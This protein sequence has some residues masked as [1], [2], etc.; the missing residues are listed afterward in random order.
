MAKHRFSEKLRYKFDNI[1]ARGTS[2]MIILLGT[3]SLFFLLVLSAIVWLTNTAPEEAGGSYLQIFWMSLMRTL[4]S[5]T[6]GGDS[7]YFGLLMLGVTCVGIFVLSGL[8][9][10][11]N[12]GIEAKLENIRKGKSKVI[13]KDHTVIFGWSDQIFTV[14]S[15]LI[16]SN[17]SRKKACIV[18]MGNKEKPEIE[19][20]IRAEIPDTRSTRIVCR[21]GDP[22]D[23][24]DIEIANLDEARSII[25]LSPDDS[26]T[27]DAEVIKSLLAITNN[28]SRKQGKYNIVAEIRDPKNLEI[29]KLVG[30]DEAEIILI[31]DLI[32]RI[33]A[34]T[35][36]QSGLSV[37]YNELLDFDGAEIY[38]KNEAASHG[39][40]Y[41]EVL[42][43][44]NNC[45]IMGII[46]ENSPAMLNPP[47][48][49]VIKSTDELVIIAGDDSDIRPSGEN[50][51]QIHTD[52]ITDRK[53]VILSPERTLLLGWNWRAPVIIR[54]LDNYVPDG[55]TVF[56]AADS[57]G[58]QQQIDACCKESLRKLT[59]QFRDVDTT[60]RAVLDSLKV[61][62]YDHIILLCYSDDLSPQQAD[63]RT[64]VTLLHLRDISEKTGKNFNIV[65]EMLNIKNRDLAQVTKVNDFIVSDKIVSLMLS[66]ISENKKINLV[67]SDMFDPDG[68]EIYLKPAADY[69]REGVEVNFATVVGSAAKKNE[70]AIGY[71]I[72]ALANDESK[73]FGV[74]VNPLKSQNVRFAKKDMVI[75]LTDS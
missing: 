51:I 23:L 48:D 74:C 44:Y 66:Q 34:Q 54:E 1:M 69:V 40:K 14:I 64:L 47:M 13:E 46:P 67:F 7:G 5:G 31:G 36:R 73:A 68:A 52:A 2:S 19:D 38:I 11:I 63:S 59:V 42:S 57:A 4:D 18:V 58:A 10:I 45:S 37:V 50:A 39:K 24:N 27:P 17:S 30:K 49:R 62:Q 21:Q 28:P 8:I 41:S 53:E 15:E 3:L 71:K 29:A 70:T 60:D 25:I 20:G 61:E 9:G 75:V 65:S 32:S 72:D 43:L 16:V 6:M 35:C 33:I 26:E 12:N 22:A 56:V 55:S